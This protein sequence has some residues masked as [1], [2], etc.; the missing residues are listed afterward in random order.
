MTSSAGLP[1]NYV[2]T[3]IYSQ[4]APCRDLPCSGLFRF[5]LMH[6]SC[7]YFLV[8]NHV[9]GTMHYFPSLP[10]QQ[11]HGIKEKFVAEGDTSQWAFAHFEPPGFLPRHLWRTAEPWNPLRAEP[12]MAPNLLTHKVKSPLP[13]FQD[14]HHSAVPGQ[15]LP[16]HTSMPSSSYLLHPLACPGHC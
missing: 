1:H 8:I 5:C 10:A 13:G 2:H 3:V 16:C 9:S 11:Y 7:E 15:P 6:S 14:F 4:L 12:I